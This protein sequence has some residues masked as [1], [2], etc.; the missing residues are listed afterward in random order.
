MLLPLNVIVTIEF[1]VN[2]APVIFTEEPTGP[3]FGS[4]R[5]KK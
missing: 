1:G 4:N 2:P 5:G 3:E